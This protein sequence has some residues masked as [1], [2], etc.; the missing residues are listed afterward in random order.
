MKILLYVGHWIYNNCYY[1]ISGKMEKEEFL[2]L[3]KNI[4]F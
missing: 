2:K 4:R 3:L 1:D